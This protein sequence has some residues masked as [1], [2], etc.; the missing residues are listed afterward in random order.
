MRG[1]H[2]GSHEGHCS[3]WVPP[4]PHMPGVP[5]LALPRGSANYQVMDC[6]LR[7]SLRPIP[8]KHVHDYRE[9]RIQE[10]CPFHHSRRQGPGPASRWPRRLTDFLEQ[11]YQR[12]ASAVGIPLGTWAR[13]RSLR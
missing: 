10:G 5:L 7:T 6:C 1:S 12:P 11:S 4:P 9:Q 8:A 13:G 3:L 2:R